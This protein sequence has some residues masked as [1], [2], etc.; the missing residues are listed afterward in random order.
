MTSLTEFFNK[1]ED[2]TSL[3]GISHKN[4][5]IKRNIIAYMAVNGECTLS[6]LTK[7]LHIS[8][9]TITK[10][11]QE[12]V[13]ENIVTDQG[14]V[15]TPGGRRPN[16][17]GL[18]SSA[19]YFAGVN[20]G[21]DN[22]T[23]LISDL[24]NNIITEQ[25][26]YSFELTDRPQCLEKIC[27]NIE[28]FLSG[29]G[30]DRSKILGLGVGMTGRINPDTGRSYKYFTANE[31]PLREI[32][33]EKT[34]LR[35]LLENDT[36][37]RCYAEFTCG[38]SKEEH[39]VIYLHLGRG[40]AIGI[41]VDGKLFY[42]KSGFAGEFGHIPFF[43]NEIICSCGKKGCLETEVSGIAIEDKM[44]R[45]IEQGVN[46]ILREQYDREKTIHID[47][48]I[49]TAKNDDNLSIELIEE[50]GEK[51]G[52]AVAFLINTFNP[53]TVIVGGNL[54][55]AGDYLML[56]LKSATNKFSL[57]LVYKDTKFRVS[58]MSE[59]ANAWGVAMLIRNKIIG[60]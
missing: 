16:V 60:I 58:K 14:K 6:E 26:D 52:K 59:N 2:E 27:S 32:I 40:V 36:R 4:S 10:L 44:C 53:E 54:A 38:K 39:N 20:V 15:E 51:V 9:P 41:V 56:P 24:Q 17:F 57:N 29:C 30:V 23:F 5:L 25:A 37:A 34:G 46:T 28:E 55:A 13:D 43:D 48:I 7:E 49:A 33:E 31:Q 35:V 47:D 19:I 45:K 42:G 12:L 18:A 8:V 11:V 21:R 3:K 1:H 22:M 50:A